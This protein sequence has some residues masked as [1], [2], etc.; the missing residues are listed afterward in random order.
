MAGCPS[1]HQPIRIRE[2][3]LESGGPLQRKLN[4]RVCTLYK[5]TAITLVL[6]S[7]S[8]RNCKIDE[9]HYGQGCVEN[10]CVLFLEVQTAIIN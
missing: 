3:M 1:S 5:K 9:C 8:E 10:D 4:F 6:I 2:E 7:L